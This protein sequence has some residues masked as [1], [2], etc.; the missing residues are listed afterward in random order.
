[1]GACTQPSVQYRI[2]V[3]GGMVDGGMVAAM[4]HGQAGGGSGGLGGQGG[5]GGSGGPRTFFLFFFSRFTSFLCLFFSSL[6]FI[7][8]RNS[9]CHQGAHEGSGERATDQAG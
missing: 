9:R 8:S 1:M 5:S 7:C 2:M 3:D 4:E 6:L